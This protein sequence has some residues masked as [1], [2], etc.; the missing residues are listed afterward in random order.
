MKNKK[1]LIPVIIL[2]LLIIMGIFYI[3]LNTLSIRSK[4]DV[5]LR[6]NGIEVS[7][8]KE[9][10]VRYSFKNSLIFSNEWTIAVEYY[11]E[12][13]V[14]YFYNYRSE[15]IVFSSIGGGEIKKEKSEYKHLEDAE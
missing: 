1:F 3:V 11:D 2:L 9:V 14:N 5:H 8:V 12:P 15:K 13:G 10:T 6:E 7:E 4:M